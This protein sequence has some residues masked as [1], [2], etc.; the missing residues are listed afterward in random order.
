MASSNFLR[1]LSLEAPF[2]LFMP[3]TESITKDAYSKELLKFRESLLQS[4]PIWPKQLNTVA[5]PLPTLIPGYLEKHLENLGNY[6]CR[7]VTSIVERWWSDKDARFWERMPLLEHQEEVLR[8]IDGPGSGV[9][10][11]FA[12]KKGSWR[13]DFLLN[14]L[15]NSL[16]GDPRTGAVQI[17]E[18]NA[19]FAFNGFWITAFAHEAF[20]KKL[21]KNLHLRSPVDPEQV[22]YAPP[23]DPGVFE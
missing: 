23:S 10:E 13:P 20:Q 15:G 1:Q 4:S 22:H 3:Q 5:S 17:C 21:F 6:I 19:R 12:R 7:A 11:P 16:P 14:F 2:D 18:I 8:W 9:V